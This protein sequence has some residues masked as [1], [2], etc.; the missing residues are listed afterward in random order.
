MPNLTQGV[1]I[2][3]LK[4]QERK[5]VF[6]PKYPKEAN[7]KY[8]GVEL[9]FLSPVDKEVLGGKLYDLGMGKF[10]TLKEDHSIKCSHGSYPTDCAEHRGNEWAHELCVIA[11]EGEFKE[12]I[13]TICKLLNELKC[14]VNKTCGMHVHLDCRN[15]DAEKVYQNLISAQGILLRMN[16]KSRVEKYAKQN[17]ERDFKIAMTQGGAGNGGMRIDEGRYYAI[18]AKSFNT[19]KTI[20]V[21]VHAGT[22]DVVKI[23]NWIT[24]LVRIGST[25]ERYV[26]SFNTIPTFCKR[27]GINDV[28]LQKYIQERIDKFKIKLDEAADREIVPE[29]EQGV[30]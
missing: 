17:K 11:K 1:F 12:V 15:R 10:V 22:V 7:D 5:I 13:T 16:P 18:N 27:F 29:A 24:M 6:A 20:E 30:A 3:F 26:R 28:D 19:H 2:K 23:T 21:R 14:T 25:V 9:E 8:V 4:D